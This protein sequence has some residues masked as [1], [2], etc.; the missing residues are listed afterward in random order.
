MLFQSFRSQPKRIGLQIG[1]KRKY[2]RKKKMIKKKVI[3]CFIFNLGQ[4]SFSK[5]KLQ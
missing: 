3:N 4:F 2:M 1:N 5:S